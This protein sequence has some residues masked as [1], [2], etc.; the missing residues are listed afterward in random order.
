MRK[1]IFTLDNF[2]IIIACVVAMVFLV[3]VLSM[4]G[5]LEYKLPLTESPEL[6]TLITVAELAYR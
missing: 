1:K 2:L 6:V 3:V 5:G 4:F